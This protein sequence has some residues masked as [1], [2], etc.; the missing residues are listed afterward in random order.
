MEHLKIT[1]VQF[2][3]AMQNKNAIVLLFLNLLQIRDYVQI[4]LITNIRLMSALAL[5]KINATMF[6]LNALLV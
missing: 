4:K 1:V 5:Q 6:G 3:R 2:V